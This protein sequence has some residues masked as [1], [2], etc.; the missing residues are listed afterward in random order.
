MSNELNSGD[1][2][3]EWGKPVISASDLD[4]M[5]AYIDTVPW[6]FAKTMSATPHAYTIRDWRPAYQNEFVRFVE[7]IRKHGHP[8]NFYRAVYVYFY[9]DGLKYWTMGDTLDGT[10]V[11]NRAPEDQFFGRQVVDRYRDNQDFI[12]QDRP[13]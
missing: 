2:V 7:L 13:F 9:I 3:G 11:I 1:A 12:K 6:K 8:E 10:V 5:R 4:W